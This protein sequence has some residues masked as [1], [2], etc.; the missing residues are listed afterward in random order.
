VRPPEHLS[1]N[2]FL[3]QK[4]LWTAA[5]GSKPILFPENSK[6]NAVCSKPI[7]FPENSEGQPTGSKPNAFPRKF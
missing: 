6:G 5:T 1:P 7:L 3:S 4:I 2:E